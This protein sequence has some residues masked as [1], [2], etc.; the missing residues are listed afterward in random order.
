MNKKI[1]V[2]IPMYNAEKTIEKCIISILNQT[3]ENLEII[4]INDG[5]VDNS[6]NICKKLMKKDERIKYFYKQNSGVS[7]TRN[8]GLEKAKG[9]YVAFVDSDDFLEKNMYEL[10]IKESEDSDVVICNYN[11]IINDK[12]IKLESNINGKVCFD[13]EEMILKIENKKINIYINPPW[14]KLIK[15]QIIEDN[16]MKFNSE[17]S[18]GEDLIFNLKVMQ[19]ANKIKVLNKKLYNYIVT[20]NG[21]CLKKRNSEEY[22]RESKNLILELLGLSDKVN[23]LDNIILNE[24]CSCVIRMGKQNDRIYAKK[25]L[26][27]VRNDE[28]YNIKNKLLTKKN[29]IVYKLLKL[30]MYN[31]IYYIFKIKNILK[32]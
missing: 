29:F 25:L 13:L 26:K 2:I 23:N 18:L 28:K 15:K 24:L 9:Y 27:L 19:K 31:T 6:E 30:K 22:L 8:Y 17:I 16:N 21:L 32:K 3:Y 10:M 14:N 5:S 20:D 11:K 7:D 12:E 1:S 4:I